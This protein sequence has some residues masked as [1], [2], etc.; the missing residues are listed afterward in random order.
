M[1]IEIASVVAATVAA[2]AAIVGAGWW[3]Y[4]RGFEAGRI[5]ERIE[6][7]KSEL[8]SSHRERGARTLP[9]TGTDG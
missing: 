5:K 1:L 6:W 3:L 2:V 9:P 7:M 8:E 4:R